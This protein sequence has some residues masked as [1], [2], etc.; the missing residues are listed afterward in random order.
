M[1]R[2]ALAVWSLGA[3]QDMTLLELC[4][5]LFQYVCRLRRAGVGG[6]GQSLDA[7]QVRTEIDELFAAMRTKADANRLTEDFAQAEL[8]LMCFVDDAARGSGLPMASRWKSLVAERGA[9]DGIATFNQQLDAALAESGEAAAGRVAVFLNCMA[10]GFGSAGGEPPAD[11]VARM[12]QCAA[13]VGAGPQALVLSPEAEEHVNTKDLTTRSTPRLMLTGISLAGGLLAI[14]AAN[15]ASYRAAAR[16]VRDDLQSL[17]SMATTAP[18]A[19]PS[20]PASS[21]LSP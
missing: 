18:S 10:L 9:E 11:V 19:A 7:S 5:P 8:P 12:S 6:V 2:Q 16:Q 13:R 21:T 20:A 17:N 4:E 1:P 3:T 14:Y 15:V